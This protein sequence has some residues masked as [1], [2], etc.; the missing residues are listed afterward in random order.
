MEAQQQRQQQRRQNACGIHWVG[1][2]DEQK[3]KNNNREENE[4]KEHDIAL[5]NIIRVLSVSER[6][7]V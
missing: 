2:Q 4:G 5:M 1:K 7:N 6:T 3:K